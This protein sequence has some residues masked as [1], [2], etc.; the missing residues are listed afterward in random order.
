MKKIVPKHYNFSCE[1]NAVFGG[2]METF[3]TIDKNIKLKFEIKDAL[4]DY[5]TLLNSEK[6]TCSYT[7]YFR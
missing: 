3:K 1:Q 5:C 6:Y 4:P 7:Y 2:I